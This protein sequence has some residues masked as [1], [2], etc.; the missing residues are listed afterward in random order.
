MDYL[1]RKYVVHLDIKPENIVIS[2][3]DQLKLID[4]GI[5]RKFVWPEEISAGTAGFVAPE[6]L[7]N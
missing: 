1:H 3:D 4:L 2:N 5:S 7:R 6:V